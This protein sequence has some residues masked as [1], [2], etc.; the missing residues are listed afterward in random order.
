MEDEDEQDKPQVIE[1]MGDKVSNNLD[2]YAWNRHKKKHIHWVF[3]DD[4]IRTT[5]YSRSRYKTFMKNFASTE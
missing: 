4:D 1:K 2:F 3:Q 5:T